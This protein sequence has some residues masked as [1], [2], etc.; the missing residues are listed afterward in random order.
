MNTNTGIITTRQPR[1]IEAHAETVESGWRWLYRSAG[2]A[3]LVVAVIIPFQIIVFLIWPPPLRGGAGDWF[4]MFQRNPLA[5]LINLDLLLVVDNLLGIPITLALYVLLR[6]SNQSIMVIAAALGFLGI[7]F[8]VATNPAIQM[9]MLSERYASATTD[10]ERASYL[11]AGQAMLANWQGTAFH[12]G[13]ILSSIAW[14]A[15]PMVMLRGTMFGRAIA[16]LGIAANAIALGLYVPVVGLYLAVFSVLFLEVWYI[17]L[18]RRL[19]QFE[20]D[21]QPHPQ[22]AT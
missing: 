12:I 4:V 18:G 2:V 7:I 14:I 1:R 20:S 15:I 16:Y 9:L 5:G 19:L 22:E 21:M 13:Y 17:L 8:Y 6:R 3:A 11:A 10:A